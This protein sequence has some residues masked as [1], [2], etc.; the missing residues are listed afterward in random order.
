MNSA[1][2]DI[3]AIHEKHG[4]EVDKIVSNA[5]NELKD[6]SKKGASL[7]TVADAWDVIQVG[8][9]IRNLCS[10]TQY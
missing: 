6:V 10:G 5:Y 2:D 7:D 9:F 1:F 3:D 4:D 8:D